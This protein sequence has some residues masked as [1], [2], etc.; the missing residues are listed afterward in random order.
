MTRTPTL[1]EAT[2]GAPNAELAPLRGTQVSPLVPGSPALETL[3]DGSLD[4]IT[5]LA[6]PGTLERRFVLAHA[7]RVLKAGGRLTALE[8][9]SGKVWQANEAGILRGQS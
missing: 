9:E 8:V 1:A 3:N 6:P 2:Y 5:V 4:A 7:L